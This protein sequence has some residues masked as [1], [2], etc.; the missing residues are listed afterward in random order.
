MGVGAGRVPHCSA[1]LAPIRWEI[2]EGD[3]RI[4][5]DPTPDP[6]GN[7]IIVPGKRGGVRARVLTGAQLPAQGEAYRAHWVT[8]PESEAFKR[9]RHAASPKCRGCGMPMPADLAKTEEW[10][11]HPTCEPT[12]RLPYPLRAAVRAERMRNQP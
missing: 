2:T 8:C 10:I 12:P 3:R 4:P 5:L 11:Y 7:V 1:C 9:R 6:A